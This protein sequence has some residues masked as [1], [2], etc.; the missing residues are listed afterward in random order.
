L[1]IKKKPEW[2][3]TAITRIAPTNNSGNKYSSIDIKKALSF[4]KERA[5]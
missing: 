1:G 5:F 3:M 4:F 2:A